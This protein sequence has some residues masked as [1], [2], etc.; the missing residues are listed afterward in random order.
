MVKHLN[1][2]LFSLLIHNERLNVRASGEHRVKDRDR[3]CVV[4]IQGH[5]LFV[6]DIHAEVDSVV[7]DRRLPLE[8]VG[9]SLEKVHHSNDHVIAVA[10]F[11]ISLQ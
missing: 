5:L 3:L 11:R 10:C 8:P 2:S 9:D 6:K 4:I 1:S 7:W